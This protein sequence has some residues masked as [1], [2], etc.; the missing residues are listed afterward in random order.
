[1]AGDA[2][3]LFDPA[4]RAAIGDA[5]RRIVL[6]RTLAATLRARGLARAARFTWAEAARQT[7]AVYRG[8]LGEGRR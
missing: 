5:L 3:L 7:V 4:D 1:M 6:D 2:A 8:V